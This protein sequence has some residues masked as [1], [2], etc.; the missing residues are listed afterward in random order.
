RALSLLKKKQAEQLQVSPL[1]YL[2]RRGKLDSGYG[3]LPM[4]IL[5][6]PSHR[7]P[8]PDLPDYW[9]PPRGRMTSL[10]PGKGNNDGAET[11]SDQERSRV[12]ASNSD[13]V[14]VSWIAVFRSE[15]LNSIAPGTRGKKV[16]PV[17]P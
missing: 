17:G 16:T 7:Q 15:S 10:V 9:L 5:R 12:V 1:S 3:E 14:P 6:T 11:R 2:E 8:F 4:Y 13:L